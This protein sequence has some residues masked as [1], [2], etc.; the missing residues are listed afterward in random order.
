[1][2]AG[3]SDDEPVKASLH[4]DLAIDQST[5]TLW[6]ALR[7]QHASG[8]HTYWLNPGTQ[9]LPQALN[10][11]CQRAGQRQRFTGQCPSA[12]PLAR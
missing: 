10:G 11:T 7:L 4:A 3:K 2:F 1:M 8:W 9:G 12:F 5:K 6:I